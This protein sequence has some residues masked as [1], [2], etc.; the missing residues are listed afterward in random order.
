MG[1]RR[2]PLGG[3]ALPGDSP[4]VP[5]ADPEPLGSEV[6]LPADE[7][8]PNA[9]YIAFRGPLADAEAPCRVPLRGALSSAPPIEHQER[10]LAGP[11]RDA[12]RFLGV[13][14]VCAR[15]LLNGIEED[16]G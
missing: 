15:H 6:E 14:P 3:G 11:Q 12:V 10:K 5:S 2:Y 4:L 8:L 1:S 9:A 13:H 16:G 7:Y